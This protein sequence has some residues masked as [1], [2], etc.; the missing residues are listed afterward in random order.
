MTKTDI[1]HILQTIGNAILI[2][3]FTILTIK[4]LLAFLEENFE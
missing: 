4:G 2:G 1:K 3:V